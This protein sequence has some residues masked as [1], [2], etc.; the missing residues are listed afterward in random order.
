VIDL[1][2]ITVSMPGREA[3]LEEAIASVQAQTLRPA[4][5]LVRIAPPV[6]RP[7]QSQLAKERNVLIRQVQTEWI[8]CLDDDDL[9]YP[10]HLE[11]IAPALEDADIVYTFGDGAQQGDVNAASPDQQ[12]AGLERSNYIPY[13]AAMR[14]SLVREV[15]LY[16]EDFDFERKVF[17]ATGLHSEDWDLWVRLLRQGAR[18]R[19]V[20]EITWQYRM[21]PHSLTYSWDKP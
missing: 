5:H 3:I 16:G 15:G 4:A 21:G 1:T 20:P 7:H 17:P 2:V 13:C 6:G 10:H 18:L 19:C 11:A 14:T 12:L 8:A 9:F